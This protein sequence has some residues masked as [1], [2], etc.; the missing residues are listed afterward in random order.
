M[1]VLRQVIWPLTPWLATT[2]WLV[3]S[4]VSALLTFIVC[5]LLVLLLRRLPFHRFIVGK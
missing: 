5:F 1:I 2:H 3:D 4:L